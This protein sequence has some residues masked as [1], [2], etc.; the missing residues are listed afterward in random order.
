MRIVLAGFGSVGQSV[1]RML[2]ERA[3]ALYSARGL[4][5]RLVAVLD[6]RGA[7]ISPSG[8]DVA[9]LIEVKRSRGTVGQAPGGV[10]NIDAPLLIRSLA[11]DLLIEAS[12]STLKNPAPALNNLKAAFSSGKH[13]ISVNKAPLAL[14][15]PALMELARYNRVEFR[16]SGSVGAGTPVLDTARTLARGDRITRV[17]AILNG[18]TNYILWRMKEGG[19]P[20][21]AAL[22]EA[23]QLGYAETD[24]STDVDGIDTATKVVI[25]ASA[26]LGAGGGTRPTMSDVR[27]VGIR[28]IERAKID[29]AAARGNVVKLIGQIDAVA[30]TLTVSPEEVAAGG[31]LDVP[32]NL[33][34]V[35]F[36]LESSGE[37]SLIGRGAGGPET[38]TAIIRDLVDIWN[39]SEAPSRREGVGGGLSVPQ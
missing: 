32:R 19:A 24:P 17:R 36:T 38:A 1:A 33:N 6:S 23:Q 12:P 10:E 5:P 14:A 28:S 39:T 18:T 7:A 22:A 34:A 9:A 20:Y 4:S 3:D 30:R 29:Q 11:A 25:L 2:S 31:P 15:M 35:Q 26:V 13:A 16:Y 8:L 21:E 37:V 27:I